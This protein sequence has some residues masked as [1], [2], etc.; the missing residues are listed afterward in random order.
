MPAAECAVHNIENKG[1]HVPS[2]AHTEYWTG[3]IVRGILH[4]ALTGVCPP[5]VPEGL[6]AVIAEA[7]A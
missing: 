2:T 5:D 7:M 4:T 6:K 1:S 3:P